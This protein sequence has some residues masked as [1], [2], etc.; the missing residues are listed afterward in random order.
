MKALVKAKAEP[1]IW[2]QEVPLPEIGHQDVLMKIKKMAICG[3]DVHIYQW[4]QWAK[5]HIN[6]P[7][8]IGHEF[9]GEIVAIGLEV[10]QFKIG[11]RVS[12]EG[13]IACGHCRNC[14]ASRRHLCRNNISIGVTRQGCFAEYLMMPESNVYAI[15]TDISDKIATIFDPLGN[16]VHTALS[17]DL[18][19]EDVLITG[20]GPTGIMAAA[21]AHHVGAR[22]VV[23]ADVNEYRLN[24]AKQL[25]F[26]VTVNPNE[27]SLKKIMQ[28]LD[29]HEGFDVGLEMS[30]S[31]SALNVSA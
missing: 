11:D 8:V 24:L 18:A 1:G 26:P 22:H 19:G 10:S 5:Q 3:T 28:K 7:L 30:G 21:V 31:S 29:M 4:D 16:A 12:A 27:T 15:P 2:M 23:I 9:M 25:K 20:A 14:R 13:H 6:I 17:Y